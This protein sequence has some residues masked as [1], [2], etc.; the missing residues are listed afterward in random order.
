MPNISAPLPNDLPPI[1]PT[2]VCA[3]V[4]VENNN[5]NIIILI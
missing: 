5:N 1:T 4:V 2:L 3:N